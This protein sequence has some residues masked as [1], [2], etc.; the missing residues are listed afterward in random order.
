MCSPL[1]GDGSV[2]HVDSRT[3][4][5]VYM[6][7]FLDWIKILRDWKIQSRCLVEWHAQSFLFPKRT[8]EEELRFCL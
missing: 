3:I 5:G 1:R 4:S 7:K 6:R 2:G 8:A